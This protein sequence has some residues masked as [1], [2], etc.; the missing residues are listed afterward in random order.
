MRVSTN[1][2]FEALRNQMQKAGDAY[3]IAQ[4]RVS[5]G[6][7]INNLGDDPSG[8]GDVLSMRGVKA[9][10]EQYGKN[11][12]RAKTWLNTSESALGEVNNVLN[13]ANSLAISGS[14]ATTST[15]ARR[16]MAAEVKALRDQLISLGNSKSPTGGFLFAGTATNTQP[17]SL[18]TSGLNFNG[19]TGQIQIEANAIDT[20]TINADTSSIFTNAYT[21]LENLRAN[22][23][24]G[25]T[26]SISTTDI[27][28]IQDSISQL[29]NLRGEVGT[30]TKSIESF[31]SDHARRL[32]ELTS[33]IS[34]LE[35]VDLAQA[36]TDYK[37]AETAYQASL[38]VVSQ[39]FRLSLMDY[40]K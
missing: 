6:K 13:R 17:F 2:Q 18:G 23:E 19:N 11:L 8:L 22:L 14:T 12:D 28:A 33:S 5:S 15:E 40:M 1:Y 24:S 34:D 10:I 36:I 4:Q 26:N 32:E 7:R 37:S 31:K 3:K 21:R 30:R 39:G 29:N 25:N 38:Q 9:S 27:S 35:D 16:A 20:I